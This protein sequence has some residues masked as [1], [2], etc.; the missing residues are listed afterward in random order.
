MTFYISHIVAD[1]RGKG[2]FA[3]R[4]P[5]KLSGF[6]KLVSFKMNELAREKPGTLSFFWPA[7]L[8]EVP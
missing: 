7:T 1:P 8:C 5:D 6:W 3:C 4:K 2:G